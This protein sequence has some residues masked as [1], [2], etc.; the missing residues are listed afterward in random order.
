MRKV[1]AALPSAL[2]GRKKTRSTQ[3]FPLDGGL[4]F[5]RRQQDAKPSK[6][7]PKRWPLLA[8]SASEN[9]ICGNKITVGE[10][11]ELRAHFAARTSDGG[12]QPH[13]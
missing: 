12:E 7:F 10:V 5:Q 8:V 11:H 2:P 9:K 13:K 6:V 1:R 3:R 4:L